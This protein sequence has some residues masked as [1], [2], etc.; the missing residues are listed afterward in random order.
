MTDKL[1]ATYRKRAFYLPVDE[2][3]IYYHNMYASM[4]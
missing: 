3:K 2:S 1:Q 4:L